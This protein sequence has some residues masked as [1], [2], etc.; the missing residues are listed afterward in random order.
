MHLTAEFYHPMFN[1]LEVIVSTNKQTDAAEN[2]HLALLR[3]AGG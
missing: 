2:I 3:Y 1:R